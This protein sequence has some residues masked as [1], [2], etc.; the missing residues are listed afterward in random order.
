MTR[1]GPRGAAE[2][3]EVRR[4]EE[5]ERTAGS[6]GGGGKPQAGEE[7]TR[8][9]SRAFSHYHARLSVKR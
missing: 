4:G 9:Q 6:S 7:K 3:G 2:E 1:R 5:R 8:R